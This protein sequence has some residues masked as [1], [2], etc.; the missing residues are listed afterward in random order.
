M[1]TKGIMPKAVV[2]TEAEA[3]PIA[4]IN[5]ALDKIDDPWERIDFLR[6]WR[7]GDV[8]E[9]PEYSAFAAPSDSDARFRPPGHF[10][11]EF[12]RQPQP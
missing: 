2:M 9:W 10:G 1:N 12:D 3:D 8:S 11:D 7:E 6:S 4:A 5:F